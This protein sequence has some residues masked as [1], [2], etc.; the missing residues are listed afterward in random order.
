MKL[1]P[2]LDNLVELNELLDKE[3]EDVLLDDAP[4]GEEGL[5]IGFVSKHRLAVNK[6]GTAYMKLSTE[7]ELKR[8]EQEIRTEYRDVFSDELPTKLPPAGGLKHRIILKDEKKLIKGRMMRIP[9]KYL[10]AFKQ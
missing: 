1:P 8:K 9:N 10:K 6:S 2:E 3:Y 4:E 5:P 7:E